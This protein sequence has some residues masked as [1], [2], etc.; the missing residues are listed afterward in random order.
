MDRLTL[1]FVTNEFNVQYEF[2]EFSP[3]WV[4]NGYGRERYLIYI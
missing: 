4:E 2:S 3:E 1:Y